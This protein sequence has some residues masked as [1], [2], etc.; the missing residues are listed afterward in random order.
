MRHVTIACSRCNGTTPL[1]YAIVTETL[2]GLASDHF[3]LYVVGHQ[4]CHSGSP[5]ASNQLFGRVSI[6]LWNGSTCIIMWLHFS[7]IWM[8]SNSGACRKFC[9]ILYTFLHISSPEIP[10]FYQW[11]TSLHISL[12]SYIVSFNPC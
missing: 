9:S 1:I 12:S 10:L 11:I 7:L 6:V 4:Q 2:G 8:A 3:Y 5:M